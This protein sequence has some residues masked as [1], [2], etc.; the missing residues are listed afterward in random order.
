[1]LALTDG[2]LADAKPL[3]EQLHTWGF[4]AR[5]SPSP[6]QG[7]GVPAR[8][9]PRPLAAGTAGAKNLARPHLGDRHGRARSR[10]L[11]TKEYV[12]VSRPSGSGR[13]ARGFPG[14]PRSFYEKSDFV[15]QSRPEVG[16]QEEHP[17]PRAWLST[18][19]SGGDDVRSLMS[20]EPDARLVRRRLTTTTSAILYY[21]ISYFRAPRSPTSSAA[22]RLTAPFHEGIGDLI[23]LAARPAGRTSISVGLL[24]PRGQEGRPGPAWLPRHRPRRL[25]HRLPAVLRRHDDPVRG[26]LLLGQDPLRRTS[27]S[28]WW[29]I[30]GKYPGH[31]PALR[32][33]RGPLRPRHRR[34]PTINDDPGQCLR[35][36]EI[37]TVL[38]FQLHDHIA[39]E[40]LKQ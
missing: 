33:R 29:S 18:S 4:Q 22:K 2:F 16:P 38:K 26:R 34:R 7:R 30:V 6:L 11:K 15:L 14:L 9:D 19:T 31:R 10:L 25:L 13:L 32:P 21:Y 35:P 12:V 39:R 28:A 17:T 37:G 8:Q 20:V 3:Y 27:N 23:G 1:M 5:I 24:C 40:I 36:R